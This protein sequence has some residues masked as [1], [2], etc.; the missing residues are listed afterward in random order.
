MNKYLSICLSVAPLYGTSLYLPIDSKIGYEVEQMATL[1]NM[2]T[3]KMPYSL[4]MIRQY[5]MKIEQSNPKLFNKISEYLQKVDNEDFVTTENLSFKLSTTNQKQYLPNSHGIDTKSSYLGEA[6]FFLNNNPYLKA[7]IEASIFQKD[8]EAK[9]QT[10]N[11]YLSLGF[12]K[13]QVDAGYRDHYYGA[14]RNGGIQISNNAVNSPSVT[15]SNTTPFEFADIN[16]EVFLSKLESVDGILYDGTS[17]S[18][19]PYL[20][21]MH[22]GFNPF[23]SIEISLDRTFQFGGGA[24]QTS[25]KDVL[26]AFID[27][28]KKDNNSASCNTDC[29]TG[30]QQGAV[31]IKWNGDIFDKKV[32]IYGL[33]GGEDTGKYKNYQFGNHIKGGGFFIPF[34]N[35]DLSIR[36]ETVDFQDAW[37]VH[38]L[39]K[40]GYTNDGNVMGGWSGDISNNNAKGGL[41]QYLEIANNFDDFRFITTV[42]YFDPIKYGEAKE[43]YYNVNFGIDFEKIYKHRFDFSIGQLVDGQKTSFLSYK[44]SFK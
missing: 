5:N 36:Y 7:S 25:A 14:F 38:H 10:N 35:E 29:E 12:D 2:P 19:R 33:Y 31:N 44:L 40:N 26:E 37:Y 18:G 34:V 16:Y 39:Y 23:E 32:I 28:V 22:L 41:L 17:S 15:I 30:N 20:L 4:D 21:G 8:K 9:I 42:R 6:T 1:S 3:S 43:K 24:R 27:P 11:S 13:F